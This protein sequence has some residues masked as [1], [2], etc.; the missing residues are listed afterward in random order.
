MLK[1]KFITTSLLALPNFTKTFELDTDASKLGIGAIL[2]QGGWPIA[3]FSKK[4]N[5][6]RQTWSTFEQEQYAIVREFKH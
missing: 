2:M 1:Q 4:L 6:T 3:Y 5:E